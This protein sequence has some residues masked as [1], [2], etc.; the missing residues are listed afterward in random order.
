MEYPTIRKL[1]KDTQ[2]IKEILVPSEMI[3]IPV[4][5]GD[6]I[7]D[8]SDGTRVIKMRTGGEFG[9]QALYLDDNYY[10]FQ[11]GKDEVSN[12]ILVITRKE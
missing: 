9:Y 10:N 2:S 7:H 1:E 11:I 3:V 4:F 6:G 5:Q 12:L 8:K